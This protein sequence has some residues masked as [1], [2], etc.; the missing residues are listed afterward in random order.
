MIVDVHLINL[1]KRNVLF[2]SVD[3]SIVDTFINL[4]NFFVAKEGT[5]LYSDT[6]DSTS[7]FLIVE[8]EVK[9]KFPDGK[10]IKF[11]YL[12]DFFGEKEIL[13]NSPR[14]SSAI[15]NKECI[16]YR[17]SRDELNSLILDYP[18]IHD[19]FKKGGYKQN[20]KLGETL[21]AQT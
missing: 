16:L 7:V 2:H 3:Q 18:I 8:G 12:L 13:D 14:I 5:L 4:K 1:L 20:P 15:A 21:T 9:I 17:M 11:K 10:K 19:N 6:D